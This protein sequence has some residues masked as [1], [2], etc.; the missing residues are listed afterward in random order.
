VCHIQIT[1]N[2][3]GLESSE[4]LAV[5]PGKAESHCSQGIFNRD[6]SGLLFGE[7]TRHESKTR[8]TQQRTLS[9]VVW[10]AKFIESKRILIDKIL[11]RFFT[12]CMGSVRVKIAVPLILFSTPSSNI[13]ELWKFQFWLMLFSL[14]SEDIKYLAVLFQ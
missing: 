8:E 1:A 6:K 14:I 7:L 13:H 9:F 3:D 4:S 2:N 5:F 11:R 12:T 10:I